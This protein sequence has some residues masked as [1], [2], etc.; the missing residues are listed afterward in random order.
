M[1]FD[2]VDE[3]QVA[4]APR[5]E[6]QEKRMKNS[7]LAHFLGGLATWRSIICVT[8]ATLTLSGYAEPTT[9][10]TTKPTTLATP[11]ADF[12]L[13]EW[14][15]FVA[16]PLSPRANSVAAIK[17]TLP[18]FVVSRRPDAQG[19]ER[20]GPMPMG[21][22]RILGGKTPSP[23]FDVL[24]NL[25]GGEFQGEWPKAENNR[26]TRLLW[27]NLIADE[28]KPTLSQ[29]DEKHWMSRMRDGESRYLSE[30]RDT[31][32]E[33]FLLY[34]AEPAFTMPLRI[35]AAGEGSYKVANASPAEILNL[36]MYKSKEG[37]WRKAFVEKL[38][39]SGEKPTSKPIDNSPPKIK[40]GDVLDVSLDFSVNYVVDRNPVGK[41]TDSGDFV[42][43]NIG[44]I[45]VAGKTADQAQQDIT[46]RYSDS[47][48]QTTKVS[49]TLRPHDEVV[50][51]TGPTGPAAQM[52]L[53]NDTV[54]DPK[55][56]LS[57]WKDRLAATGLTPMD[58][59]LILDILAKYAL[60]PD[61]LTAVYMLDREQ[62]DDLLPEE[63]VPQ[64]AKTARVGLVIVCNIDPAINQE[65]ADLVTQLGDDEW[66]TREAAQKK[67]I[68]FGRAAK[69]AVE[70][71][72]KSKDM[73]VVWRA[74]AILHAIDPDKFQ[75]Q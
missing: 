16:E 3:R 55:Q 67:L 62:M 49:V 15:I 31:R 46:K 13:H 35:E 8:L 63:V 58:T 51:T 52:T 37:V 28:A 4:K 25:K 36:E 19:E 10:P 17:S 50:P 2:S 41:V 27:S 18:A 70:K 54:S 24:L 21:V 74:E 43:P 69:S 40:A 9:K 20:A 44:P 71:A 65:I 45:R 42:L 53:S 11:T 47:G 64:P 56:L 29:L 39:A 14:A 32:G 5:K 34:D 73:E 38:G 61:R 33:R 12:E 26:P 6:R 23:K 75:P 57:P 7:F 60:E 72:S 48:M 68:A 66:S 22:I 59:D 30:E 1:K